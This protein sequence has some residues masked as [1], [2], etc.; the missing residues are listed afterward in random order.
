[1]GFM[2]A[3]GNMHEK[4][5]HITSASS[6]PMWKIKSYGAW[7][8]VTDFKSNTFSNFESNFTDCGAF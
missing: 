4:V 1:M 2:L 5:P 6:L 8:V 3:G 7:N